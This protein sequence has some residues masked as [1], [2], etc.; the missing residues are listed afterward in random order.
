MSTRQTPSDKPAFDR[1]LEAKLLGRFQEARL[2]YEKAAMDLAFFYSRSG[3]QKRAIEILAKTEE[4]NQMER[5]EELHIKVKDYLEKVDG[6]DNVHT[7][8][9]LEDL[10]SRLKQRIEFQHDNFDRDTLRLMKEIH[11]RKVAETGEEPILQLIADAK[12]KAGEL[13]GF[14]EAR[15][16]GLMAVLMFAFGHRCDNDPLLPWISRTLS[17][18]GQ[19]DEA[20]TV[21]KDLERR[22]VIWLDA[23][24]RNAKEVI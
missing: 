15:S 5:A 4:L 6:E 7:L 21:A 13:Y 23:V 18:T 14:E 20:E 3:E 16:L 12:T 11:P 19:V 17:Q 24:L 8:K 22:A 2:A 10:S 1:D 9:A